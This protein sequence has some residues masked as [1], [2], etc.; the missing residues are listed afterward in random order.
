[1]NDNVAQKKKTKVKKYS[2]EIETNGEKCVSLR[3]RN[4]S[5]TSHL[6]QALNRL[7]DPDLLLQPG[8]SLSRYCR[9]I[10]LQKVPLCI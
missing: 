4:F 2:L 6:E 8:L 10:K 3:L 1:M 5:G 9:I 7:K